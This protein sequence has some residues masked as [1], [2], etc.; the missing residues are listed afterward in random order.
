MRKENRLTFQVSNDVVLNY[1][2][3]SYG[4]YMTEKRRRDEIF[5]NEIQLKF[6]K[7]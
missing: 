3:L 2:E 7:K 4:K 6:F 1:L 5:F